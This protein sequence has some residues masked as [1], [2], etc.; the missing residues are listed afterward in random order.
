LDLT[1]LLNQNLNNKVAYHQAC[2]VINGEY[3]DNPV[4]IKF[5]HFVGVIT[6]VT[7]KENYVKHFTKIFG[8]EIIAKY[9]NLYQTSIYK[10]AKLPEFKNNQK[11]LELMVMFEFDYVNRIAAT[12]SKIIQ[13]TIWGLYHFTKGVI[14]V[15]KICQ[16]KFLT[17]KIKTKQEVKQMIHDVVAKQ[18]AD[19]VNLSHS[20]FGKVCDAFC[21]FYQQ[22]KNISYNVKLAKYYDQ[23]SQEIH[24]MYSDKLA[25]AFLRKDFDHG[26]SFCKCSKIEVINLMLGRQGF[27]EITRMFPRHY[28]VSPFINYVKTMCQQ[29]CSTTIAHPVV[30]REEEDEDE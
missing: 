27:E 13:D 10:I 15:K 7:E 22:Y 6:K 20:T 5:R 25:D 23:A 2:E 24:N 21:K 28:N 19:S 18:V 3:L 17:M 11:F 9:P 14:G 1:D 30:K 16:K 8:S 4:S 29:K 12:Q 26:S